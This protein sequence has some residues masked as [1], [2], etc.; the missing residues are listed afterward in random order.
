MSEENKKQMAHPEMLGKGCYGKVYKMGDFALKQNLMDPED[1]QD[2]RSLRELIIMRKV[3]SHP[4][5]IKI[6][7]VTTNIPFSDDEKVNEFFHFIM[8]L[9]DSNLFDYSNNTPI[10]NLKIVEVITLQI[11]LGLEFLHAQNIGHFDLKPENIIL[12]FKAGK[13]KVKI[14]DFGISERWSSH[15]ESTPGLVTYTFRAPEILAGSKYYDGKADIW[16]LGCIVYQIINLESF[17]NLK[18][19]DKKEIYADIRSKIHDPPSLEDIACHPKKYREANF[20]ASPYSLKKFQELEEMIDKMLIFNP[21]KRFSATQLI[22]QY[23]LNKYPKMI[24]KIR[25]RMEKKETITINNNYKRKRYGKKCEA[26]L[27][28]EKITYHDMFHALALYDRISLL[29]AKIV[30]LELFSYLAPYISHIFRA[31]LDEYP[32]WREFCNDK[33]SY[34]EMTRL[35]VELLVLTG[36]KIDEPTLYEVSDSGPIFPEKEQRIFLQR[37][38]K[39]FLNINSYEGEL[40]N[41]P[42]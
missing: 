9:G 10:N 20:T 2:L 22:D 4:C 3:N 8:E 11:L 29:D 39:S 25:Q 17:V 36:C 40:K 18:K 35:L 27:T 37:L 15:H 26:M 38:W 41:F 30:D 28:A 33:F 7:E 31:N 23:F 19:N 13:V 34:G 1:D 32:E 21:K 12:N 14:C 24:R 16:S 42:I 5:F 6:K